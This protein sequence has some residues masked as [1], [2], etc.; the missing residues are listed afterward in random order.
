MKPKGMPSRKAVKQMTISPTGITH[1]CANCN[2]TRQ[3]IL[4]SLNVGD[5]VK[6]EKYKYR[7]KSAYR[8][9]DINN[10]DFGVINADLAADLSTEY[11][12]NEIEG[13]VSKR[14]WFYSERMDDDLETCRVKLF[15][16]DDKE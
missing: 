16:L 2:F 15:I 11:P 6:I 1:D 8:L 10:N 7:G 13:Y 4:S 5:V 12:N 9:N 3:D 14:D